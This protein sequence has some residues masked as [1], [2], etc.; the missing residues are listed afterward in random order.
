MSISKSLNRWPVKSTRSASYHLVFLTL[1]AL[2]YPG[3]SYAAGLTLGALFSDH[4]VLQRDANIPVWGNASRGEKV[5]VSICGQ[6]AS[7]TADE[8]GRWKLALAPLKVGGP[9]EMT[10]SGETASVTIKDVMVGDVW[11]CSGQSNMGLSLRKSYAPVLNA[12]LEIAAGSHPNIR[13]MGG[14]NDQWAVCSP[15]T[16]PTFSA[17]AYF[18]GR[19]LNQRMNVPIGLIVRAVGAS[20]AEAWTPAWA[21]RD[22]PAFRPIWDAVADYTAQYPQLLEKYNQDMVEWTRASDE[23][24]AQNKP[25][26][27]Q[28]Y[29]PA[30]PQHFGRRPEVLFDQIRSLM[31]YRIK[32]VI[33]YQGEAN[34]EHAYTYRKLLPALIY[35]W[36]K[37]WGQGDFPFLIVQ[38][39]NYQETGRGFDSPIAELREAQAMTARDVPNC[40]LAVTIDIGE[41]HNIHPANK[42]DVGKRLALEALNI[43]YGQNVVSSGPTF[44]HLQLDGARAIVKFTNIGGGLV[45][46]GGAVKGF[47][48]AG[49]DRKFIPADASIEG[50]TV[51]VQ[52]GAVPEP[53]AVRYA[54]ADDPPCTLYNSDGL[55][56]APFRSDDWPGVTVNAK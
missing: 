46:K 15:A 48:L 13:L 42:Q 20:Y 10:V 16:L 3:A 17:V 2:A 7:A 40:G 24:K 47:A 38:L 37:E 19:E 9:F 44:S 26:P 1:V 22:D 5:T 52:S 11:V 18:F 49:V 34:R 6:T 41:A 30:D 32:G 50:D 54:W 27:R 12:E 45:A 4:A 25:A 14:A 39:P 23:A 35:G 31:P 33:W 43:V 28:P 55:P 29:K 53:V 56:A 36:R 51:I 21:L 8:Q